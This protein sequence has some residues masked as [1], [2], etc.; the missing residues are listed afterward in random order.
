MQWDSWFVLWAWSYQSCTVWGNVWGLIHFVWS[1]PYMH[2]ARSTGTFVTCET[3]YIGRVWWEMSFSL[4]SRW[5]AHLDP[6]PFQYRY[7]FTGL[8]IDPKFTGTSTGTG[9][10]TQ[11]FEVSLSWSWSDL[12]HGTIVPL[13]L[14]S[15]IDIL[16]DLSWLLCMICHAWI[17]R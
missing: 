3:D 2:G 4:R 13:V 17:L 9:T 6:L 1:R 5:P 7:I 11:G 16:A 10:G 12:I 15:N 8:F 14:R